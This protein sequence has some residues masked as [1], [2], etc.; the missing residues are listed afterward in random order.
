MRENLYMSIEESVTSKTIELFEILKEI[1]VQDHTGQWLN[2]LHLNPFPK[3]NPHKKARS[4]LESI[5]EIVTNENKQ[6]SV[7][8][9]Y[10]RILF[11]LLQQ[12]LW[13]KEDYPDFPLNAKEEAQ[14]LLRYDNYRFIDVPL[15]YLSV[16]SIPFQ[17]G[18]VI[19][20][21][22]SEKDKEDKW[23]EKVK[24][25][26]GDEWRVQSYARVKSYGDYVKA[27]QDALSKT[28]EALLLL[29]AIGFPFFPKSQH[30]F[31]ILNEYPLGAIPYR[32]NK[33]IKYQH[34]ERPARL[35]TVLVQWPRI[36]VNMLWDD[37]LQKVDEKTLSCLQHLV[38]KDFISP[39]SEMKKKFFLGLHWLGE[40]TKP[41]E[42]SARF[43]K[44]FISLE[45]FIGEGYKETG[46]QKIILGKR[47]ASVVNATPTERNKIYNAVLRYYVKRSEIVHGKNVNA[48]DELQGFGKLVRKIAWALLEKLDDFQTI[49]D[50]HN[51]VISQPMAWIKNTKNKHNHT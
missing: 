27:G 21:S 15:E 19:F 48:E 44:L 9:I 36:H 12:A 7:R 28:A 31:G 8:L 1:E 26:G 10:D 6:V 5:I 41:D 23:W 51:W 43:I 35:S 40:A 13:F 3:E 29:R 4:L 17:L 33:P 25:N 46:E 49:E 18:D 34:K 47:C 16:G 37:L 45:N 14:Y 32:S 42:P 11:G 30:Q 24:G 50:L 38:E 22:V 39:S 2:F 20:F